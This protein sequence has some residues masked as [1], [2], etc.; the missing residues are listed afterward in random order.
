MSEP[1]FRQKSME[2]I[3]SPEE[4]HD[5][6]KVTSPRLW[7]ILTAIAVLLVGFI[8]Y[9]STTRIEN[10]LPVHITIEADPVEP[11][12]S[13]LVIADIPENRENIIDAGMVVRL[14]EIEGKIEMIGSDQDSSYALIDFGDKI[15]GY[16]LGEYEGEVVVES[17]TPMSFLWN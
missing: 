4:L 9:A 2:R 5:Y 12:T 14:G 7:M 8:V 17:T 11:E 6:M 16:P 15:Q 1:L 3:S 10:T 13:R